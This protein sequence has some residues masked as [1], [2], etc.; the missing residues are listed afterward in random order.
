MQDVTKSAVLLTGGTSG[1]GLASAKTLAKQGVRQFMLVGRSIDRAIRAAETLLAVTPGLDVQT[2]SA[3]VATPE[4]ATNAAAAC[5]EAF[6]RIDALVSSSGGD[7]TPKLIHEMP[8]EEVQTTIGT[9]ISG[10]VLPAR[11]VLHQMTAQGCGSI[12]CISS[13]AAKIATPGE[14]AIGAAMGGIVSFCRN[15][16]IEA[17]RSGIRVNAVTPSIVRGTPLYDKVMSEPF[18]KKLFSKAEKNAHLG[19]VDADD[20]AELIAFLV[21]SGSSRLTGQA[22]SVNGGI[23]AA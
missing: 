3:D 23:S 9:I 21:S 10:V 14:V 4:G 19:V 17:K 8:I 7:A 18:P 22:I 16:A 6:G 1:I 11:A 15:L 12:V 13:D 20:V 5:V 2:F